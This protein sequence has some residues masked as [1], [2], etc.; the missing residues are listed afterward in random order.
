M[1]TCHSQSPSPAKPRTVCMY[2]AHL[3]IAG[4]QCGTMRVHLA[5]IAFHH[6]I[7]CYPNPV[8]SFEVSKCLQ[9]AQKT[10]T[11]RKTNTP[12]LPTTKTILHKLVKSINQFTD[13]AYYR[14]LYKSLFLLSYH[15]CLR[16]GEAVKSNNTDNILQ[17]HQLRETVRDWIQGFE[18]MFQ[19]YKHSKEPLTLF[20]PAVEESKIL[21]CFISNSL[22]AGP[23]LGRWTTIHK[24]SIETN[25]QKLFR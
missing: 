4:F 8:S 3:K 21:P 1:Q 11:S 10:I 22:F 24:S 14:L 16:A 17:L 25:C 5:A 7:N 6:K 15:A 2:I 23:G 12:R 20:P 19:R 9:G 13:S 18:V